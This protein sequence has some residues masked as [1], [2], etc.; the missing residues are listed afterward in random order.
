MSNRFRILFTPKFADQVID[1][2]GTKTGE[3]YTYFNKP[4]GVKYYLE[5]SSEFGW[6]EKAGKMSAVQDTAVVIIID[7]DMI[8]LRP[9]TADFSDK[10]VQFWQPFENAEIVRKSRVEPGTP[11]GQTYGAFHL[12]Q[13]I[14]CPSLR[15]ELIVIMI[16]QSF[17]NVKVSVI[18]GGST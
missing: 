16:L 1:I 5:N 13:F 4:F 17:L 6:D 11:F 18:I 8:L 7:P 3:D 9:L 15:F 2:T 14:I 12:L 10:S